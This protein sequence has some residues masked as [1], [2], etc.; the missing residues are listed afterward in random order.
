M[1]SKE[2]MTPGGWKEDKDIEIKRLQSE[3]FD[4]AM[5]KNTPKGLTPIPQ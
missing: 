5:N 2:R 3:V 4:I 1:A